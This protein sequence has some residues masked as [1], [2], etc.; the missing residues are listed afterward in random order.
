MSRLPR[1]VCPVCLRPI[2]A[3][4]EMQGGSVFLVKSCP[5][6]G[7]FRTIVWRGQPDFQDWSRPKVPSF[8]KTPFSRVE[9]GCPLDCGLCDGHLQ[10][11]CTAVMEITWRCDLGC[12]VCFASSGGS[13]PPDPTVD[14]MGRLF[15]R[16]FEASGHCNVQLSGGEPT[17]RDDLPDLI[18]LGKAKGFPFIQLNTNGLR[19]GREH[20]YAEVL[21]DAGLDSVFLQFDGTADSI[22]STLRGRPLLDTKLAAVEALFRAGIGIVLVPTVVPGVNDHDLGAI[23]RLAAEQSPGVRGVHF[24]PVSYFGRYPRSPSDE[25]RITLPELMRLLEKQTGGAVRARDFLPPGCEHSHCSFHANYVVAEDGG[26]DK[27]SAGGTCGCTPRPASEGADKAK[28]FVKRQWAAPDKTLPMADAPDALDAF[29]SRAA[30]HTLA[31]SAMAFQD[32]WTLDLERL[33]GCCIHVVS[34]DGRLIPFCAYNL[35]SMDGETLYRG[36]CGSA[37]P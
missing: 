6:H 28:A 19:I 23:L 10:H 14:E 11:T 27:L 16:V 8:P 36:K 35:T 22:Y 32:A 37:C 9:Q 7:I 3:H 29:I 4:H 18:R 15:D 33:K 1:S 25:Q 5:D 21:A 31:V 17:V 24:Q 20:G 13:A 2:P 30:T 34:P 12:P 26:L